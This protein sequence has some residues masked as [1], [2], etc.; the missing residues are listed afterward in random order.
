LAHIIEF[1]PDATLAI[2]REGKVI[3]WNRAIEEMTGIMKE[4]M[5]GKGNYEYAIPLYGKRRPILVD[6]VFTWHG[7]VENQYSFIKKQGDTFFAETDAPNVHGQRR[8]LWAKA[9]P[10]YD[11]HGNIIGAIESIRDV[12]DHKEAVK[13]IAEEREKLIILSDNAPFGMALINKEGRFTYINRKFVELFGYDFPEI[14]EIRTWF[15]KAFPD[16]V[17]RENVSTAAKEDFGDIKPGERKPR[18]LTV[19]CKDKTQK[20][21][22]FISSLLVSGDYL[23][24]CEDITEVKKLET[25]L[26]QSQKME[27][28]G[29]LAGGIAHD[30]NNI[31][32]ALVGYASLIQTSLGPSDPV[33]SYVDQVLAASEKAADLTRSLLAFSRRQPITL[34]PLS[35]NNTVKDAEK[36]LKRLLT[37][38]IELRIFLN[39]N[40]PIAMADK[41][42]IDQI[43]FNLVT[44]ARDAMPH[45]GILTVKTDLI[46]LDDTFKHFHGYGEKGTYALLSISDTGMG[47]NETTMERIFDPFFTTKEVGRGT[48][49]GLATVYGIVKQHNGY[50]NTYSEPGMGTV[51]HIYFPVATQFVKESE[52][53]PEPVKGGNETILV[54]EDS[55]AVRNLI[56]VLLAEHGYSVVEAIDGEDAVRRFAETEKIDLVILDTVMPKKNGREV[57]DEII[58]LNL[59]AKCTL[60]AAIREML[61]SIKAWKPRSLNLSRNLFCPMSSSKR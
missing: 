38:D 49:L 53:A 34:I 10:L 19:T 42:Q 1:F 28:I 54:A 31:L 20:I 39:D 58:R 21:I 61:S 57:Y 8:S 55:D 6:F 29:T 26:R 45:G 48:G 27:A 23:M 41:S 13:A 59:T 36:L 33:Q 46:T 24:T 16:D 2:D 40:D 12:T 37:E 60:P 7:D 4:D 35:F 43:L 52:T 17:Y 30:F 51:F 5:F 9:G 22:R 25:Q 11:I 56:K 32:T 50:I 18:V 44:N 14:P 47:M 3:A 15:T